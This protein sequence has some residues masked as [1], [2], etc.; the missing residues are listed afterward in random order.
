M[1]HRSSR[2]LRP[3]HAAPPPYYPSQRASVLDC[4]GAASRLA[5]RKPLLVGCLIVALLWIPGLVL[6]GGLDETQFAVN[7]AL[8]IVAARILLR[9]HKHR[10]AVRRRG[11]DLVAL[12]PACRSADDFES[13]EG[14]ASGDAQAGQLSSRSPW[15]DRPSRRVL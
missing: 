11:G 12:D 14:G 1:R 4:L 15:G 13:V 6:F 7:A 3:T 2:R 8:T 9:N 5:V 10:H